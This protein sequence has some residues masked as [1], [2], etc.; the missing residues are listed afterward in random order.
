MEVY[1]IN[2]IN[3]ID[4]KPDTNRY[5]ND[6]KKYIQDPDAFHGHMNNFVSIFQES[7]SKKT[8]TLVREYNDVYQKWANEQTLLQMAN[9]F[10]ADQ[11]S[12][13][14]GDFNVSPNVDSVLRGISKSSI[15]KRKGP[16]KKKRT[17]K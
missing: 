3:S 15:S 6:M 11:I 12:D 2:V 13:L 10:D 9:K 5:I 7:I 4:V 1:A 14:F 8:L 16:S 17:L